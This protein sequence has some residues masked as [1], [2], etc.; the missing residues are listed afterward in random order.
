MTLDEIIEALAGLGAEESLARI[1]QLIGEVSEDDLAALRDAAIEAAQPYIDEVPSDESAIARAEALTVILDAIDRRTSDTE[2]ETDEAAE[3][4][5]AVEEGAAAS[6]DV[7]V[8]PERE[9]VAAD[10][11]P[12][13]QNASTPMP[14][15]L[16]RAAAF[17][18]AP[19][20]S[21]SGRSTASRTPCW[22]RATCRT[23]GPAGTDR[24][25]G[26]CRR[27]AHGY[28]PGVA[29]AGSG[30]APV[31]GLDQAQGAGF[32]VLSVRC[33]LD[34]GR[35]CDRPAEPCWWFAHR[36]WRM[37][38][39]LRSDV[40]HMPHSG[41]SGRHDRSAHDHRKPGRHQVLPASRFHRFLVARR[42]RADRNRRNCR[43]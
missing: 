9:L 13:D 37:V 15:P 8:Q 36:C 31:A 24:L 40:R 11:T 38:R 20:V 22:L 6:A 25:Q 12:A 42:V 4:A 23:T 30:C 14:I 18:P 19:T 21:D 28:E 7:A 1:E 10:A 3:E 17:A 41:Q 35:Q 32:A 43:S 16:D 39:P 29:V 27:R 26:H 2:P 5:A 34:E 33:G